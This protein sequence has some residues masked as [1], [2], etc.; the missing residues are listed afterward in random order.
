MS[1]YIKITFIVLV[2][3]LLSVQTRAQFI[4]M[5]DRVIVAGFVFEES[6]GE[7]LAYVNVFIKKTVFL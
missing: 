3:L 5:A 7:A 6:T 4:K 2:V 1:K